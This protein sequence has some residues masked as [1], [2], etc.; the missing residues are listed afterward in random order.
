MVHVLYQIFTSDD[1]ELP[2]SAVTDYL[3]K[4]DPQMATRYLEYLIEEKEEQSA[5]FHDRLAELYLGISMT[6]KRKGEEGESP[7]LNIFGSKI[8]AWFLAI[9]MV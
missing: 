2:R 1:V 9:C 4:F 7:L 5:G 8:D 3:E 6:A